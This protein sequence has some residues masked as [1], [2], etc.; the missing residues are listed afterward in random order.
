[1]SVKNLIVTTCISMLI[2]ILH[3][4]SF[5]QESTVVLSLDDCIKM[6][7][8][9]GK[10]FEIAQ[11]NLEASK[12]NYSAK[13]LTFYLPKLSLNSNLPN[14]DVN[15]NLFYSGGFGNRVFT[16]DKTLS[17]YN[18]LRLSQDFFTGGN[19]QIDGYLNSYDERYQTFFEGGDTVPEK[20]TQEV[21]TNVGFK[22]NQPIMFWSSSN[23]LDVDQSKVEYQLA[24]KDYGEKI[25]SLISEL[26]T[27]YFDLL[28]TQK[29]VMIA[30]KKVESSKI[31]LDNI[32]KMQED[33]IKSDEEVYNAE[34]E[35]LNNKI[36]LI[37]QN[38][39]IKE[40]EN[41]FLQK[42]NL[43]TNS[44]I[45]LLDKFDNVSLSS[46]DSSLLQK[47]VDNSV[48][49]LKAELDVK[50][51][52]IALHQQQAAG[53]V[54]G[55][56]EAT[57]GL[58]G[59]GGQIR[60][61]WDDLRRNRWGININLSIPI[62]DGGARNA[63]LRSLQLSLDEAKNKLELAR[64][65]VRLHLETVVNKLNNLDQKDSLL[66]K[67]K[68]I[69]RRKLGNSQEKLQ[70]GLISDKELLDAEVSYLETEKGYLENLKEFYLQRIELRKI[71]GVV[72]ENE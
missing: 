67:E 62:W 33:G 52:E 45:E 42:T 11:K 36:N 7:L 60:S 61:S 6:A 22:F 40:L 63:S 1:M 58:W 69:A 16:R 30:E 49:S 47:S 27:T 59:R 17:Y 54:I 35:F 9:Q 31:V 14:Y 50:S 12:A 19:L 15:E 4:I 48:G 70:M 29:E 64:K 39:K 3:A 38:G 65:T 68:D 71:W 13:K 53:G 10:E 25:N 41:N 46:E 56:F 34:K 32:R 72:P 8:K 24:Q 28:I 26:T 2:V 57:Y 21:L 20:K 37:D 44:K 66:L 51:K 43:K 18:A 23:R 5:S 55:N